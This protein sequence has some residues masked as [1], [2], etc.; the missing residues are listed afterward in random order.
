MRYCALLLLGIFTSMAARSQ[1][2][3][4]EEPDNYFPFA[5]WYSGGKARATMLSD[6][7]P[8]SKVEWRHDL[9]EIKSLGFNTV[10]TWVE[11]AHCE[12]SEGEWRFENLKLLLGLAKEVGLKVFIQVYAESAPEWLGIKYPNSLFEAQNGYRIQSQVDPGYCVDNAGIRNAMI[13]FY[14]EAAKIAIQYSNFAGWDVW[15]EPHIVQWGEPNWISNANYCYCPASQERFR[16]W[17]KKKY[18]GLEQLNKAWYRT[19]PSWNEVQAPRFGTIL[20]YTDFTDWR[21]F[22]ADKMAQDL[23]M[24]YD[25]IRSVDKTHVITSHASP[26]S[27]FST[28]YG[29]AEN[30]FLMSK[31]VD[32]YGLSQYPMHSLPGDWKP[33]LFDANADFSYSANKSNEGYYVGELQAGYGT[34]GLSVGDPVT[35]ADQRIWTWTSLATGAKGIFVYAY[36]PMSSGYESGGYGLVNLDGTVTKRA[37]SLGKIAQFVNQHS[38]LFNESKPINPQIALVYNPLAQMVGGESGKSHSGDIISSL[39][40]YYRFFKDHN[41]PVGFIYLNDL[42]KINLS[43]YKM[44]IVPYPLMFTQEAANALKD[45]VRQGGHLLSEARLAWN[46]SNG[47]TS[48][49]IPGMG[50]SEVFGIK[51]SKVKTIEGEPV[52]IIIKNTSGVAMEKLSIGDTIRGSYFAESLELLKNSKAKVLGTLEDGTPCIT[53]SQYGE[54][55]TMYVGSFLFLN[56]TKG[57]LWDQSA[58]RFEVQNSVNKNKSDFLLG[59]VNWAHVQMPVTCSLPS[60]PNNP[61]VL[62]LQKNPTGYLLYILNQGIKELDGFDIKLNIDAEGEY[63]IDEILT[64]R[65][66]V[67]RAN[68]NS[69]KFTTSNIQGKDVEIWSIQHV[70]K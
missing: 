56:D 3:H 14:Q 62:R 37:E 68:D 10:K 9:E 50:L 60:R 69:L 46:H 26:V 53:S 70:E 33:W 43:H 58:N 13:K 6:I 59:L 20:T 55:E 1:V 57:S 66:M 19:F 15:S 42:N 2:N 29:S 35:P 8:R 17:L 44:I 4:I 64:N 36:Y 51:E 21:E 63:K 27:L 48:D 45:Y 31:Q 16:Q 65:S 25:A 61:V 11:W 54:G 12:P 67:V 32:Y 7:T 5:V 49:D 23:R 41:I 40:G 47:H 28:P 52:P 30:D 22:N 18:G 24:R 34:V 38:A 39:V